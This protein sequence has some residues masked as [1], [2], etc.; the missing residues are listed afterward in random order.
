MGHKLGDTFKY[1]FQFITRY[2]IGFLLWMRDAFYGALAC[3]LAHNDAA[4]TQASQKLYTEAGTGRRNT[5]FD[6]N[7]VIEY[8]KC[9]IEKYNEGAL[10]SERQNVQLA[11]WDVNFW[12]FPWKYLDYACSWFVVRWLQG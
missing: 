7:C 12:C 3:V 6:S 9:A 8:E 1:I 4:Q 5:W 2:V 10:F 11:K